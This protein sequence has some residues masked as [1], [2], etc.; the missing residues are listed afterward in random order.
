VH[1]EQKPPISED[2]PAPTYK[3]AGAR[4]HLPAAALRERGASAN[5]ER[6][7]PTARPRLLRPHVCLVGLVDA[8]RAK[9]ARSTIQPYLRRPP[10]Y[11][12]HGRACMQWLGTSRS[13]S[14]AACLGSIA[15]TACPACAAGC[16]LQGVNQGQGWKIKEC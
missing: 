6:Q 9:P 10:R 15:A 12:P 2:D 5:G 7:S 11:L 16:N 14:P 4:P 8:R 3:S 13:T 1:L